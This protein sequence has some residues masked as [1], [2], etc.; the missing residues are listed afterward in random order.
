MFKVAVIRTYVGM[1]RACVCV[2]V[3]KG[4]KLSDHQSNSVLHAMLR[5]I[6]NPAEPLS[7]GQCPRRSNP[8]LTFCV[9]A[10]NPDLVWI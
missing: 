6:V 4:M 8:N 3:V 2:C 7:H 1:V 9:N 10:T 5:Q